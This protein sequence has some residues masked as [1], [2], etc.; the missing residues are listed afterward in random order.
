MIA[1][2][3]LECDGVCIPQFYFIEGYMDKLFDE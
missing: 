1:S 2:D 3:S